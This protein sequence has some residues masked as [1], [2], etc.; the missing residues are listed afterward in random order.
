MTSFYTDF[1]I[2]FD[3]RKQILN[4]NDYSHT[5]STTFNVTILI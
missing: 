4:H 1:S 2:I 3:K 5:K